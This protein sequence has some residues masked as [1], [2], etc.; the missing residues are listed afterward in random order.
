MT[1]KTIRNYVLAVAIPL[2]I[3]LAYFTIAQGGFYK[4]WLQGHRSQ[5]VYSTLL[6]VDNLALLNCANYRI[7]MVYPYDFGTLPENLPVITGKYD[8]CIISAQVTAG[9]DLENLSL[10]FVDNRITLNLGEPQITS[11]KVADQVVTGQGFPDMAITPEEWGAIVE[12]VTPLI[13]E[14]SLNRG[15]IDE[16]QGYGQDFFR[17]LFE[18]AGYDRVEFK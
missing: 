12:G 16:A 3:L 6:G 1:L 4:K 15:I 5:A 8:F 2:L 10:N 17:R 14:L 11:F 9:Y 18:G 7:R 13:E